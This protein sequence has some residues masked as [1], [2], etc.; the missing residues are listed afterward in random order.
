[1]AALIKRS[2][3]QTMPDGSVD[4]KVCDHWTIQYRDAAGK[5]QRVKGYRDKAATKQLAAKIEQQI[6]RGEQAMIDPFKASK[7]RPLAEHVADYLAN[8]TGGGRSAK[9]IY[10]MERR[11]NI[12]ADKCG[13][14][15]LAEI[16]ANGFM[17]WRQSEKSDCKSRSGRSG[18]GASATTLNQYLA[19]IRTFLAWCIDNG[20]YGVDP[21]A[22]VDKVDGAKVR[23]RRA[24]TDEQVGALL[25]VADD[26]RRLVYRFGLLTGLR[27]GE[28]EDLEWGDLGL[29]AIKPYIQLRAEATKAKRADR[30][31][32]DI[33]LA[34]DL[35]KS[36]PEGSKD[37]DC[38]FPVVPSIGVWKADLE[39]AGIPYKDDQ[40]RQADFHAGTRKTLCTRLNRSGIAPRV[41]MQLMRHTDIK[42]TMVDYTDD[43]QLALD[44]AIAALPQI[45]ATTT[46]VTPNAAI[47][48]A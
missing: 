25:G 1:M 22:K 48:T 28:I 4:Q 23:K 7:V 27:R 36:R 14:K 29:R 34:N 47:V 40:G 19:S 2:Y 35:R 26:S 33:T 11:L 41:A 38:V 43:G 24:L 32:L 21:M 8:L 17:A 39:A 9:Y 42:L 20:R 13:W 31:P 15:S 3:K 5:I 46:P 45:T 37:S 18:L 44:E 12:L 10:T 30:L 6:A 16:N